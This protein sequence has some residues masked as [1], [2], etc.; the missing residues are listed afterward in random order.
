MPSA[1][2]SVTS[3]NALI[4]PLCAENFTLNE[5]GTPG[6]RCPNGHSFDFSR[7]GYLNLLSGAP[8]KFTAESKQMIQARANFLGAGHFAPLSEQLSTTLERW[9]PPVRP[10]SLLIDAGVGIGHYLK[11]LL[12][13][14][15]SRAAIGLDLSP[16]A[17]RRASR[18]NPGTLQLVWDVWRPW[19]VAANTA[20]AIVVVFAPRNAAEYHRVL[21]SDGL[22]LVVTPLTEH[23]SGLPEF[24]GRLHQQPGKHAILHFGL[25]EHFELL[26]EKEVRWQLDLSATE[27]ADL[28][29]MGPSGHHIGEAALKSTLGDSRYQVQSA[30]RISAFRP[31]RLAP[32]AS[33]LPLAR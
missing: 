2:I 27:A 30:V 22:L 14:A 16:E 26:E 8:S 21:R 10:D 25:A 29:M 33:I 32:T 1:P 11:S 12:D 23:L 19:P 5:S 28:V 31:L 18:D 7:H 3:L 20:D 15:G 24:E 4:C 13:G 9:T 17:L 6:V